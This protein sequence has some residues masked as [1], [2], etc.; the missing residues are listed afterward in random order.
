MST[1][2]RT[3]WARLAGGSLI[4]AAVRIG[5]MGCGLLLMIALARSLTPS[6]LGAVTLCFSIAMIGGL[7]ASLNVGAGAVRFVNDYLGTGSSPLLHGYLNF[8]RRT[9]LASAA[10]LWLILAL[11]G[12]LAPVLDIAL[13]AHVIVGLCVAP[14]FAWLRIAAA[15]VA[16]TGEVLRGAIPATLLRPVFTLVGVG[17]AWLLVEQLNVAVVLGVYVI[18]LLGVVALQWPLFRPVMAQLTRAPAASAPDVVSLWRRVGLDLLIPALFLELFVDI[19]V[20]FASLVIDDAELGALGIVLRVQGIVLFLVTSINMT[21]SPRIAA[22]H[23]MNDRDEVNR[24]LLIST[25]LKLWPSLLA[26]FALVFLGRWVL[27]LFSPAYAP[28]LVTL[29]ILSTTPLIM[30]VFGPIVLFVTIRGLQNAA[31]RVFGVALA[32]LFVLTLGLGH[33]YGVNGIAVSV[34]LVWLF[35]HAW[36]Y[37]AI[38]RESGYSTVRLTP[39]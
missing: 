34:V 11:A 24:L 25:H 12:A 32:V 2:G 35:W 8:G 15:N 5:G 31:R 38:R 28:Y 17:L 21:L 16:A 3:G 26:L 13:P 36:L 33:R 19:V 30:A 18:A 20:L 10:V 7:L 27:S 39:A 9:V 14:L 29:L 37:V 4:L 1:D 6:D 23:S 22:A